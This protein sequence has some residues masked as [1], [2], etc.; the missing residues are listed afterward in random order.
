MDFYV[1]SPIS[2]TVATEGQNYMTKYL[3]TPQTN[4]VAFKFDKE[5]R[6]M[7]FFN[8][9]TILLADPSGDGNLVKY[10]GSGITLNY[11]ASDSATTAIAAKIQPTDLEFHPNGN[12]LV[13]DRTAGCVRKITST[14][15]ISSFAGRCGYAGFNMCMGTAATSCDLMSPQY[16]A[17]TPNG[18]VFIYRK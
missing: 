17:V 16:L 12:I 6:K 15:Q 11:G 2:G 5:T 9:N 4:S 18:T 14:G 3:G 10:A 1:G 13:A 8:S 7:Y